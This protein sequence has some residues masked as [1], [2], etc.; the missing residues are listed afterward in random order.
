KAGD[1]SQEMTLSYAAKWGWYSI[2]QNLVE[3][4]SS[5][6]Q[7]DVLDRTPLSYAA[8]NGDQNTFSFLLDKDSFP[9]AADKQNRTA[10]SYAAEKN[11]LTILEMLLKDQRV[12]AELK[13]DKGRTALWWAVRHG[14]EK[15]AH[16]ILQK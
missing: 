15:A 2:V 1:N 10:L 16:I 13:D 9:D 14:H 4:G 11:H 7:R 5:V 6:G 3:N 12:N 8:A